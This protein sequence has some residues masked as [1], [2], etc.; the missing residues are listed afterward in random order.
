MQLI[1]QV[2][3]NVLNIAMEKSVVKQCPS[4]IYF[5]ITQVIN[6]IHFILFYSEARTLCLVSIL[7][8]SSYAIEILLN[9]VLCNDIKK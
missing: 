8:T 3:T 1:V 4:R 6:D 7:Y 9:Q 2:K 5:K